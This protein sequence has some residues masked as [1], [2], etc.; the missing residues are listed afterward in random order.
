MNLTF[1]YT[2]R[3]IALKVS[4]S[5]ADIISVNICKKF[6]A[7]STWLAIALVSALGALALAQDAPKKVSR[8]EAL[9]AVVTKIQPEYPAMARQLKIQGT[10][11]LEALVSETGE[12]T[13]VDIISGN[14]MLTAP[15][16]NAV[17]HWRFRPF[18][19]DGKAIRVVAPVTMDFKL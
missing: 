5:W 13:K 15:A 9:S 7:K 16:A 1:D 10:V 4:P 17:K 3:R 6:C 8:G 18:L 11:E 12:V 14:P 2:L 19:E